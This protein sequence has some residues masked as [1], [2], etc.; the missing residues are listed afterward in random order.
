MKT[1]LVDTSM[2]QKTQTQVRNDFSKII[3]A[4]QKYR[5]DYPDKTYKLIYDF[6]SDKN[7]KVVDLGCGTGIVTNHLAGYYRNVIGVDRDLK[8]IEVVKERQSE[9]ISFIQAN[10]ENLPF[11]N[12]SVDLATAGAAYHWFDYDKAG[13]EIFRVLKPD[14]KLCVF[15]KYARDKNSRGYLP[16]FAADNLKKFIPEISRTNEPISADIFSKVG[17]SQIHNEEFDFD[18]FYTKEEILGYIQSHSTF[19]LLDDK[20]KKEY[21]ELNARS[22]DNYLVDGKFTFES[23]MTMWFISK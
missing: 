23:R 19:N 17:F 5:R 6:C 10:V 1:I 7:A 8:M 13:K 4:Y 20:Q 22:V 15:W 14:G 11:E 2:E 3:D 18:D 12:D 16:N 21:I 9:N